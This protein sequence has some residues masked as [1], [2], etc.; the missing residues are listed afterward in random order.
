MEESYEIREKKFIVWL[1]ALLIGMGVLIA[2]LVLLDDT[3]GGAGT[4]VMLIGIFGGSGAL[5]LA[6]GVR[7]KLEVGADGTLKYTPFIGSPHIFGYSDID[8]AECTVKLGD[9]CM[10][11]FDRAGK[12]L[13]KLESNMSNY[14]RICDTLTA[15]GIR[16]QMPDGIY[17]ASGAG[18]AQ[19]AGDVHENGST[20]GTQPQIVSE[21]V[22]AGEKASR[23]I[24]YCVLALSGLILI[25]G[26]IYAVSIGNAMMR[27]AVYFI[28]AVPIS[29]LSAVN[30]IKS[31]RGAY[32]NG[33]VYGA[34]LNGFEERN[35]SRLAPDFI[36]TDPFGNTHQ[37]SGL[38][39]MK[40]GKQNRQSFIG[41]NYKIWYA[42]QT[43]HGV[44][45]GELNSDRPYMDSI[46]KV[47]VP[48]I[49]YLL[50]V[51]LIA[52]SVAGGTTA[53][54]QTGKSME[55]EWSDTMG[56]N[57][58]TQRQAEKSQT[59]QWF[60]YSYSLYT[61]FNGM[62]IGEI[63]GVDPEDQDEVSGIRTLL[64][65]GWNITDRDSA[66]SG[67]NRLLER[68]HRVKYRSMAAKLKKEGL[69]DLS[70]GDYLE[71]VIDKGDTYR[72]KAIYEAYHQF[73]DK[74]IDAWDYARELKL[75]AHCYTAGYITLDECL[76]Q[77][78]PVAKQLQSEYGSWE[79]M[80]ES[81]VY[82]YEF[83]CG[84]NNSQNKKDIEQYQYDISIMT[85]KEMLAMMPDYKYTLQKDW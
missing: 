27:L 82:G 73:G 57:S 52:S 11:I 25:G 44:L 75:L 41:K 61:L 8:H 21:P 24:L 43:V 55:I 6:D 69:L 48:Q 77:S 46:P 59:V 9:R 54:D 37:V 30:T 14:G 56:E 22:P 42:P 2:G 16:V 50:I 83:W 47:V 72:Y 74:G 85:Q 62:Q 53:A 66:I 58:L 35:A 71:K 40:V 60:T 80:F 70:E 5:V 23:T 79:E 36:F 49:V 64:R 78:L 13:C 17:R 34:T 3:T 39:K 12:R 81:Y 31:Q 76:D 38:T 84:E 10:I 45:Y 33:I 7:R 18:T 67:S 20:Q 65:D 4:A 63:G 28:A 68:G 32:K 29:L 19:D 26:L 51:A 15:H 1:G